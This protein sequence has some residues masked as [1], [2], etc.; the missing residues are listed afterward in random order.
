MGIRQCACEGN[1]FQS[2]TLDLHSN[3]KELQII[4]WKGSNLH[5]YKYFILLTVHQKVSLVL[6]KNLYL[7]ISIIKIGKINKLYCINIKFFLWRSAIPDLIQC[8]RQ[9]TFF[10]VYYA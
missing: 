6:V 3:V 7:C 10:T 2:D 5:V 4:Q 8:A 1:V 9:I